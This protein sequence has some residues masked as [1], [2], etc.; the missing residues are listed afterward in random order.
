MFCLNTIVLP[1]ASV[2]LTSP[3]TY[4]SA[5]VTVNVT[6]SPGLDDL[7][8]VTVPFPCQQPYW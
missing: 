7:I 2:T 5:G 4:P 1:L 6:G 8:A 3:K